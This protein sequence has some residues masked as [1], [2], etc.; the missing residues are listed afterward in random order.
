MLRS[1]NQIASASA[2][3]GGSLWSAKSAAILIADTQPAYLFELAPLCFG[4]ATLGLAGKA[5]SIPGAGS[6]FAW[7]LS[8]LATVAGVLTAL[9][10]IS[11]GDVAAF[12]LAIMVALIAILAFM[13]TTGRGL[14]PWSPLPWRL[15][16]LM[17]AAIPVGGVLASVDERLLELPLLVVSVAWILL[18]VR[19]AEISDAVRS[20]NQS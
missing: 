8:S 18:G 7:G 20:T 11:F 5:Q 15:G 1:L 12:G 13:L 19:M 14:R 16:W 4:V 10:Y 6:V 9:I 3:V 17:I 2:V